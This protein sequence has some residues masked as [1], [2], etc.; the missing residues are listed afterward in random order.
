[1]VH[2]RRLAATNGVST[3]SRAQGFRQARE[4]RAG[5]RSGGAP[6]GRKRLVTHVPAVGRAQV[7]PSWMCSSPD[8]CGLRPAPHGASF[9]LSVPLSDGM[10]AHRSKGNNAMTVM[11]DVP[12][13]ASNLRD[14][15]HGMISLIRGAGHQLHVAVYSTLGLNDC[16]LDKWH[17]LDAERLAKEFR[18]AAV[19]LN[20]PGFCAYDQATAYIVG[21]T[22]SFE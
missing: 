10:V 18:V 5:T 14:A 11:R 13:R 17:P 9:E 7:A 15:R 21:E 2:A 16:P 4:V 12:V 19:Y 3:P 22:V 20:G 6:P 1:M 8:D